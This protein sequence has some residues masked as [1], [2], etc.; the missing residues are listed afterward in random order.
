MS[1]SIARVCALSA[2]CTTILIGCANHSQQKLTAEQEIEHGKKVAV[3]AVNSQETWARVGAKR[4]T[5]GVCTVDATRIS[6][7]L[8]DA[9]VDTVSYRQGDRLVIFTVWTGLQ[10]GMHS[11]FVDVAVRRDTFEVVGMQED[12]YP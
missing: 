10:F 4:L 12:F 6:H 11:T 2:F 3:A 5:R 8:Y 1:I 7:Q 9:Q